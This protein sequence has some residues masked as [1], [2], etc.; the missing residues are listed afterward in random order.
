MG[1]SEAAFNGADAKVMIEIA[2]IA[3]AMGTATG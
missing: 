2:I 3:I 1:L